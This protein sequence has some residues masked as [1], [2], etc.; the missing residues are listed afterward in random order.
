MQDSPSRTR[1]ERARCHQLQQRPLLLEYVCGHAEHRCPH[2]LST[3]S[4]A[5]GSS[6]PPSVLHAQLD[7]FWCGCRGVDARVPHAL[8]GAVPVDISDTKRQ[9]GSMSL[10]CP[11][12][13]RVCGGV[14]CAVA[15]SAAFAIV[16]VRLSSECTKR[17]K[18]IL[19]HRGKRISLS[20]S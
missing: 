10:W 18:S 5:H 19:S 2:G 13:L 8:K 16:H 17:N 12:D 9:E 14:R 4:K 20:R 11:S 15:G 6:P 3:A 7:G 1:A